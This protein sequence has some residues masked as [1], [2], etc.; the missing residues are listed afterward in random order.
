[1]IAEGAERGVEGADVRRGEDDVSEER[2][3]ESPGLAQDLDEPGKGP[4]RKF[5]WLLSPRS[6]WKKE[7]HIHPFLSPDGILGFFNSDESGLL[8]AYMVRGLPARA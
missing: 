8:Q 2:E 4:A 3:G 7:A 6:S 5:T 1:V